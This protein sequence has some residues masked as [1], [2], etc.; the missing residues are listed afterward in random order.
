MFLEGCGG[1]GDG[2]R[3]CGDVEQLADILVAGEGGHRE[4]E[5][6]QGG[7]VVKGHGRD[8]RPGALAVGDLAVERSE[9]RG[10]LRLE[11][12]ADD[13]RVL[14][15]A[16]LGLDDRRERGPVHLVVLLRETQE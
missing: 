4:D 9:V 13:L 7:S 2:D 15:Y 3:D 14:V 10:V 6:V 1:G 5:L 11:E 16:L 8:A 12:Q